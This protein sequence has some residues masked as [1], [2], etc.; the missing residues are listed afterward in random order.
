MPTF[1]TPET[2]LAYQITFQNLGTASALEVI[3]LDTLSQYLDTS[4]L[5]VGVS[6]HDYDW[7]LLPEQ[8]FKIHF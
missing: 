5:R 8:H 4:T 2:D 1:I 7:E 3:I 6:S